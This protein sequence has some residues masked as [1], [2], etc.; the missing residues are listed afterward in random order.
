MGGRHDAH[1]DGL[2][3]GTAD[4]AHAPLLQ[5][6]QECDLHGMRHVADFV[7]EQRAAMGAAHEA[8]PTFRRAGERTADVSEQLGQHRVALECG[9]VDRDERTLCAVGVHVESARDEFLARA[10]LALD[11]DAAVRGAEPPHVVENASP[12][13]RASDQPLRARVC[14]VGGRLGGG[15]FGRGCLVSASL[16]QEPQDRPCSS[17]VPLVEGTTASDGGVALTDGEGQYTARSPLFR[18]PEL[19]ALADADGPNPCLG[20]ELEHGPRRERVDVLRLARDVLAAHV[21]QEDAPA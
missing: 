21:M 7:E 10:G 15:G 16:F 6:T 4:R 17:H 12:R 3:A 19:G 8:V 11:D 5:C 14:L 2:R 1:I 9:A 20:R 18:A 13:N